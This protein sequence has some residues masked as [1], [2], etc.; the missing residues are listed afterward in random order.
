MQERNINKF[1]LIKI[2]FLFKRHHYN[3]KRQVKDLEKTFAEHISDTVLVYNIQ[4]LRT[5]Q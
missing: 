3:M 4:S 1:D 5:Q 2:K